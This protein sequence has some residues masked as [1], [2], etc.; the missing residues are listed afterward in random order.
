MLRVLL[1]LAVIALTIYAF[2]DCIGSKGEEIRHLSKPVWLLLIVLAWVIGPLA[3]LIVGRER[4]L[5][6]R[7]GGPGGG[8]GGGGGRRGGGRRRWVAPDDNPDFLRS[9]GEERR[10]EA[11]RED[12]RKGREDHSG[13]ESGSESGS[14]KEKEK[15]TKKERQ[16][17]EA[18]AEEELRRREEELRQRDG[19]DGRGDG[20]DGPQDS[21][22]PT[23]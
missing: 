2:V 10:R 15:K 14:D 6:W 17:E 18:A 9:L 8:R 1:F 11:R 12:R 22:P 7:A 4:A 23:G 5:P 21:P 13:S 3:W 20:D 19:R 16:A